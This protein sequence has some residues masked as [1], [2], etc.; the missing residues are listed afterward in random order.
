MP[1][2]KVYQ[3]GPAQLDFNV[4]PLIDVTFLLIIFFMV[5][6]NFIT[7]ESVNMI[8]PELDEPTVRR[9]ERMDRVVVNIAPLEYD[10]IERDDDHLAWS[11]QPQYVKIG[12][13]YYGMDD[14]NQMISEL[15]EVSTS[16]T[17]ARGK[18]QL[19]VVLRAD[20]ALYYGSVQPVMQAITAAGIGKVHLVS[21]LPQQGPTRSNRPN[22]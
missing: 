18:P 22:P 1:P 19:E 3:R 13:K 9:F 4:T 14:M 15:T 20:S 16:T 6:S 2:S 10:T 7:Q 21:Y 12:T 5:I 8:V 17:D 11:G